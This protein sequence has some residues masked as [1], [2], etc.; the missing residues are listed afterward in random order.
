VLHLFLVQR[1]HRHP[2]HLGKV[3]L[4]QGHQRLH[5]GFLEEDLQEVYYQRHHNRRLFLHLHLI[6]QFYLG[7]LVLGLIHHHRLRHLSM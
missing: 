3:Y 1:H 7:Y 4:I 2:L 5:L 6:H